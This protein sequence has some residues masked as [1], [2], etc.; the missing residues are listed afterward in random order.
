MKLSSVLILNFLYKIIN[1]I[2]VVSRGMLQFIWK[3]YISIPFTVKK[4]ISAKK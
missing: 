3:K 4:N 2:F 1:S